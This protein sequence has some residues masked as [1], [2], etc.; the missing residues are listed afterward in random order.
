MAPRIWLD[1]AYREKDQAKAAGA[2]WDPQ[3]RRWY[4]PRPGMRALG[5]WLP[6]APQPAPARAAEAE[7][8][9]SNDPAVLLRDV[10]ESEPLPWAIRAPYGWFCHMCDST[11]RAG[12]IQVAKIQTRLLRRPIIVTQPI[13]WRHH[14]QRREDVHWRLL[15]HITQVLEHTLTPGTAI[16]WNPDSRQLDTITGT[17]HDWRD[18][19]DQQKRR[20]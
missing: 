3:T 2:R 12:T 6:P 11:C 10:A 19:R 7:P 17:I 4:A 8:S 9:W 18:L 15:V 1:V 14:L 20:R 16:R 5:R 13:E